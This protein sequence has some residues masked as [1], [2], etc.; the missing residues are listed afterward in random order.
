MPFS[1]IR[2]DD[3]V[4]SCLKS[5]R[6][7]LQ[8][9]CDTDVLSNGKIEKQIKLFLAAA[10]LE[11]GME[12]RACVM[13][14]K[15]NG[16]ELDLLALRNRQP[17]FWLESKCD[18]REKPTEAKAS[19]R[20][21]L[22]QV[23]KARQKLAQSW[24]ARNKKATAPTRFRYQLRRCPAYIVHFLNSTP[25]D[26]RQR[27]GWILNRFNLRGE[28]PSDAQ[29]MKPSALGQFYMG[30]SSR[31]DEARFECI[32][33]NPGSTNKLYAVLVKFPRSRARDRYLDFK[34]GE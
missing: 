13:D 9:L 30:C 10:W 6:R 3:P 1:R 26:A 27:Y 28:S 23:R 2:R 5:L 14:K 11:G 18:F 15:F 34:V 25:A 8:P 29:A 32:T 17:R 31:G 7:L 12:D 21:A 20:R 22:E 19:A 4:L 16:C 24:A 33:L